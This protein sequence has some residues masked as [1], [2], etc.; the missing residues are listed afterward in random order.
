MEADKD[1]LLDIQHTV[2]YEEAERKR[3]FNIE[4]D[5]LKPVIAKKKRFN[6]FP[7]CDIIIDYSITDKIAAYLNINYFVETEVL[8][9]EYNELKS[10]SS[11]TMDDFEEYLM[12]MLNFL[13]VKQFPKEKNTCA[14]PKELGFTFSSYKLQSKKIASSRDKYGAAIYCTVTEDKIPQPA[15]CI[16]KGSLKTVPRGN[17][18]YKTLILD[19]ARNNTEPF[20]I[21]RNV[22]GSAFNIQLEQNYNIKCCDELQVASNKDENPI[23]VFDGEKVVSD[24]IEDGKLYYFI[25]KVYE[26]NCSPSD[27]HNSN[28]IN[29][30]GIINYAVI[31]D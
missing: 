1:E 12:Y 8:L 13:Y 25:I 5:L 6:F 10:S 2:E 24:K 23:F 9:T 3:K 17:F 22:G 20:N 31:I 18:K 4:L 14:F 7:D 30:K 28:F 21:L 26:L 29:I 11:A 15:C 27:E 19:M 16:V